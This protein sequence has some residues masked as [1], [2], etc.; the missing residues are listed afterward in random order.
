MKINSRRKF[1]FNSLAIT[2]MPFLHNDVYGNIFSQ[3]FSDSSALN[4]SKI[5]KELS[6]K[7]KCAIGGD[8]ADEIFAGYHDRIIHLGGNMIF[9]ISFYRRIISQII[10]RIKNKHLIKKIFFSGYR[11]PIFN[12]NI[13][14]DLL[15]TN[16]KSKDLFSYESENFKFISK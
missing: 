5:I 1:L 7:Y 14:N 4:T 9:N 6:K 8:G 13:I 15:S 11:Y 16:F 2:S 3:P 12:L 10:S